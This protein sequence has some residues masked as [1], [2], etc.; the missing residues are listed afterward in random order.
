MIYM[1]L[2]KLCA[3]CDWGASTQQNMQKCAFT[4]DLE[5]ADRAILTAIKF[6]RPEYKLS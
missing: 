4:H 5:N 2:Y 1:N 6:V 3:S